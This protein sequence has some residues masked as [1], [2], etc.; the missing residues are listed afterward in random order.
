MT[1][2]EPTGREVGRAI[3]RQLPLIVGLVVLWMLLWGTISWLSLVTGIL[4][5]VVV[6][7]VFYLPPVDLAGRFNVFW[8]VVFLVRFVIELVVASVQVAGQAFRP[9]GVTQNAVIEVKLVT[10]SDLILTL[11]GI[12]IS[13][14]P[15]SI[16]LEADRHQ[17]ILYLHILSTETIE[18][19]ERQR[20]KVFDVERRLVRALGSR[21]DMERMRA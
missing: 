9:R 17:S 10:R 11:T 13:L 1:D 14:I 12:V 19:V 5:A 21:E 4:V 3:W 6:T 15:G 16:V 7:R 20:A 8:A 2:R 18:E